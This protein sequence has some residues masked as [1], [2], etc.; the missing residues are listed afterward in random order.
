[1]HVWDLVH[2]QDKSLDSK[3]FSLADFKDMRPGGKDQGSVVNCLPEYW[4][5]ALRH[6]FIHSAKPVELIDKTFKEI[7]VSSLVD[8]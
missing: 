1:M 8:H 6:T 4:N 3:L 2:T 7:S 5:H